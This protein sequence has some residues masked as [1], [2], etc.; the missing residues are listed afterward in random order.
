MLQRIL[1]KSQ[2][3]DAMSVTEKMAAFFNKHNITWTVSFGT[4]LGSYM[5]HDILPWDDDLDAFVHIK[6]IPKL[7]QLFKDG[8]LRKEIN[9]GM[10]VTG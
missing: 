8:T 2:H 10:T 4:L 9:F 5:S 3:H 6:D 7:Y 1:N